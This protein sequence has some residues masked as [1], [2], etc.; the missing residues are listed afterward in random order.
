M[1]FFLTALMLNTLLLNADTSF[2]IGTVK[3]DIQSTSGDNSPIVNNNQLI[4]KTKIDKRK[5]EVHTSIDTVNGDI[6]ST[7]GDKSDII[8]KDKK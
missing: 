1:K 8:N 6:Q 3:G 4:K 2:S 7:S 5:I